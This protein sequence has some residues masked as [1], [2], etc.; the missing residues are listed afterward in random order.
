MPGRQ[1]ITI[2][3]L[4]IACVIVVLLRLM[5]GTDSWGFASDDA[6]H[7]LRIHRVYVGSIVGAALGLSG[8]LLQSL[9]RH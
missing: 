4:L 3:G 8:A 1:G 7:E 6:I 5:V 2:L 9:L